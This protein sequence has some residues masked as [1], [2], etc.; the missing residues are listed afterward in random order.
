M[1]FNYFRDKK[2]E[3][4]MILEKIALHNQQN[5]GRLN[6]V[7]SGSSPLAIGMQKVWQFIL[8]PKSL[9][10]LTKWLWTMKADM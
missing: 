10:K 1:L 5:F 3:I 9:S 6:G 4:I 7:P 2:L 8:I